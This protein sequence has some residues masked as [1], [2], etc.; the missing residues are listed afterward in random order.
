MTNTPK[1]PEH[2]GE[3]TIRI[4]PTGRP[5]FVSLKVTSTG[6]VELSPLEIYYTLVDATEQVR[7]SL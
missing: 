3:I 5:G 6:P 7:A 2:T 1:T 4:Y